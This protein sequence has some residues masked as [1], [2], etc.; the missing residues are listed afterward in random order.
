MG[1]WG[2][3]RKRARIQLKE[4]FHESGGLKSAERGP[5]ST[6]GDTVNR[7]AYGVTMYHVEVRRR[8]VGVCVCVCGG[9][10]G[11]GWCGECLCVCVPAQ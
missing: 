5:E 11:G 2:S 7:D 10:G 6:P 1:R 8:G 9:G 3:Y 4:A